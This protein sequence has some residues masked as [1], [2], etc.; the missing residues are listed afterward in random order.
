MLLDLGH[1]TISNEKLGT[2]KNIIHR[3]KMKHMYQEKISTN[4]IYDN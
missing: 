4:Q 2:A 3:M 1:A